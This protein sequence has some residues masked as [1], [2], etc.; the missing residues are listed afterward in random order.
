[1]RAI[2]IFAVF[3]CASTIG[4]SQSLASLDDIEEVSLESIS[5]RVYPNP[6]IDDF[7]LDLKDFKDQDINVIIRKGE[8]IYYDRPVSNISSNT[9][10]LSSYNIGLRKG[11]YLMEVKLK[12]K[13]FK[14]TIKVI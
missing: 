11:E 5:L 14:R 4:F 3:L 2:L 8:K 9:L 12:N 6:I 7:R 13:V 10:L 1:M